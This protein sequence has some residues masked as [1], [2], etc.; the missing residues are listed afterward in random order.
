MEHMKG[1]GPDTSMKH[2][3]GGAVRGH[4]WKEEQFWNISGRS[5]R[6]GVLQEGGAG[7]EHIRK[8]EQV[9]STSGRRS[10]Y[11]AHQKGGAGMEH[12]RK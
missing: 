8:E 4:I 11:G 1:E 6:Y 5:S 3:K 12:I 10:R 2:M 7:M 9:W